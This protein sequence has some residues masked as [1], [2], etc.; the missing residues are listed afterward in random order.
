MAQIKR[1][2]FYTCNAPRPGRPKT[3]TIPVIIDQ[4]H[5]VILE[6]GRI[7]AKSIAEHL[8]VSREWVGSIIHEDLDKRKLSSKWIPKYLS[9]DQKR[10]SCLSSEQYLLF[11]GEF[12]M[13]SSRDSWPWMKPC[14][15]TK[16]PKESNNEWSEGIAAHP[17]PPKKSS[18]W[19]NPLENFSPEIF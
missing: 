5:E 6:D 19:K 13:I 7:S 12:Q 3:V 10:Q 11:F 1:G 8:S 17:A 9:R 14:Y 2:G 16:T 15:V 4:I 18:E